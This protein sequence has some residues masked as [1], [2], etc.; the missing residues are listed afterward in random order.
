MFDA[1]YN[2]VTIGL[3]VI[4]KFTLA[5]VL[6]LRTTAWTML[7]RGLL[8]MFFLFG[9]AY[10]LP[11]LRLAGLDIPDWVT[12][13]LRAIVIV[14]CLVILVALYRYDWPDIPVRVQWGEL[15]HLSGRPRVRG[16]DEPPRRVD[17]PAILQDEP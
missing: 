2:L 11:F 14:D 3:I 7:G 5:I 13:I 17:P 4:L 10:A 9:V 8:V 6:L 1:I 15:L 16:Q 12:Q